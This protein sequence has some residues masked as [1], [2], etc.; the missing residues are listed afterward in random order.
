MI[1]NL[2]L[3]EIVLAGAWSSTSLRSDKLPKP[4]VDSQD[5]YYVSAYTLP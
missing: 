3:L 5:S 2:I 1:Y 4:L